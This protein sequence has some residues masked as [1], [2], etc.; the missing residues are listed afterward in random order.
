M[1]PENSQATK[2][3]RMAGAITIAATLKPLNKPANQQRLKDILIARK[4]KLMRACDCTPVAQANTAYYYDFKLA[5]DSVRD[6]MAIWAQQDDNYLRPGL[7]N[8]A[9][10]YGK[11]YNQLITNALKSN[12]PAM[13]ITFFILSC[14]WRKTIGIICRVWEGWSMHYT[15]NSDE[16]DV[17]LVW[18]GHGDFGAC[19]PMMR[20]LY[21]EDIGPYA[22]PLV[23]PGTPV[24]I[25]PHIQQQP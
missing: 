18:M 3:F 1:N 14:M 21:Q 25:F 24:F 8:M 22:L 2:Q 5:I 20:Q 19:E 13:D 11:T 16:L 12:A 10:K 15:N 9:M 4:Q 6:E 17:I 7:W 23:D